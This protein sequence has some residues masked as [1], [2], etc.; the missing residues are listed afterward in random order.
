MK[1]ADNGN[2]YLSEINVTPLV[3]VFL[4]L[5]IIFMVTAPLLQQGLDVDLPVVE[6]PALSRSE[7]D[8]ILTLKEDGKYYLQDEKT[9]YSLEELGPKLTGI[10]ERRD[11]KEIYL[12][13]YRRVVYG[14]VV[15]AIALFKKLG[16][17]RVGMI[18]REKE[19]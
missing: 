10:F 12:N 16:I 4:V 2:R 3:D 6:A 7:A 1:Q 8:V 14:N 13:A 5:L 9:A 17:G 11:K 19:A 18:T 15:G